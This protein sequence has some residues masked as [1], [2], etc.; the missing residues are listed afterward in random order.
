MMIPR[1]NTECKH[2]P[3]WPMNYID[4][5]SGFVIF[6]ISCLAAAS[7]TGGGG[8]LVAVYVALENFRT[9]QAIPLSKATILGGAIANALYNFFQ[10]HPS[11]DRPLIDYDLVGYLEPGVLLGTVMGVYLVKLLP[12]WLVLIG[13]VLVLCLVSYK[14]IQKGITLYKAEQESSRICDESVPLDKQGVMFP[15]VQHHHSDTSVNCS[16]ELEAILAEEKKNP[17]FKLL[18]FLSVWIVIFVVVFL[19]GGEG[20]ASPVGIK[21]G[22]WS[23]WLLVWSL[24]PFVI[25]YLLIFGY[26]IKIQFDRKVAS[27]YP[28]LDTDIR[29]TVTRLVTLPFYCVA[30]GIA[31]GLFGIG[32]GMI[33]GPILLNLNVPPRVSAAISSFMIL[34]T[35]SSTT[36]QF[37]IFGLLKYDYAAFLSIVGFVG[38]LSGQFGLSYFLKAHKGFSV[39]VFI[40]AGI[41]I[42]GAIALAVNGGISIAQKYDHG[43]R[44]WS[45]APVCQVPE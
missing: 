32:S 17:W 43:A 35:A 6:L 34:F 33:I 12:S 40:L 18:S 24:V 13:L 41:I 10:R 16:P 9:N 23:Y 7:G 5:L 28:F 14:T 45:I 42:V 19:K 37:S 31:S 4:W 25:I 3:L 26:F 29:W 1:N 39:M 8:L 30:A 44:L 20:S 22:S 11:A 21:C 15:Q 36:I 27:N 38:A 2:K